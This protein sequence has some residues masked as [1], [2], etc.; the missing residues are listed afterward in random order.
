MTSLS[1]SDYESPQAILFDGALPAT[2]KMA[3][4]ESWRDDAEALQRAESEGLQGGS[5][6]PLREVQKAII[7]LAKDSPFTE[8]PP[9]LSRANFP[10]IEKQVSGVFGAET[11]HK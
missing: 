6:S 10:M 9:H 1:Y 7:A 3:L 4:L 5:D 2:V 11:E 8:L